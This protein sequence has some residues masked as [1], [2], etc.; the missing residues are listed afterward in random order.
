MLEYY[1]HGTVRKVV[2]GFASLFNNIHLVRNDASGNER[3]RIRVPIAYGPQQKFIKR[4]DRIGTDFDEQQVR[5]ETYLPRMAFEITSLAYDS[6][7]KL[8]S[9]QQ[10]VGYNPLDRG[11][12]KKRW[13]RVPYNM[14]M[15]LSAM[16]KGMEDCLQIVEQV[17]PYFTPEYVFTIKAIDGM[18]MD[19]DIPIILSSVSLSEGDDG[20]YGDY[21]QRKVNSA[22]IQFTAKMY[23][24]GPVKEAPLIL[25]TN[26]NIF[27]T[28]DFGKPTATLK[29]YADIGVSAAAGI[30]AGGY[31][32]SLTA[33]WTGAGATHANVVIR[34]YPPTPWAS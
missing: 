27:D 8:N 28:N 17:L 20:S 26:V 30:T 23:L 15:T 5:L 33:G 29:K 7:R 9:V 10:T 11:S 31:A 22:S 34:E 3:E 24:Y 19:V 2:V 13:E 12:L 4:L 21:S 6:S 32:P 16:T 18:D 1:Y 14:S 25:N